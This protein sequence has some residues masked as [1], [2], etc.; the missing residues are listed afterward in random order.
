MN[1]SGKS[2]NYWLKELKIPLENLLVIMDDIALPFGS[3]RMRVKGS[4]AGHNGLKDI[5]SYLGSGYSRLRFGVGDNFHKGY[6]ADYVLS[7]FENEEVALLDGYI[8][9]ATQMILSFVH[10]GAG[11]TMTEYND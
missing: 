2:V 5:E 3:L 9:K 11:P 1:L 6:Q 7:P 10:R 4:S 8:E